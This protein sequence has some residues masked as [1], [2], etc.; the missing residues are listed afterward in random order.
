MRP[1]HLEIEGFTAFREKVAIDFDGLDLFA[2]TGPTGAGKSSLLDAAILALYGQVPRVS[3][4]YK[5]LISHGA[6]RMSVRLDFSVGERA[7]R[8]ARTIRR[9]GTAQSRLERVEGDRVVPIADRAAEVSKEVERLLGLDYDAFV[10]SVVLPQGQ[11]DEFLKGK[12][13]ERR[14]I[15]VTLLNLDVYQKMQRL[16]NEK[17]VEARREAEFLSKQLATTLAEATPEALERKRGEARTAEAAQAAAEKA[18]GALDAML[19]LARALRDAQHEAEGIGRDLAA[20]TQ[21]AQKARADLGGAEQERRALRQARDAADTRLKKAPFDHERH[22]RLTEARPRLE[23]L[24]A[25]SERM[26]QLERERAAHTRDL[27]KGKAEADRTVAGVAAA[28][29]GSVRAQKALEAAEAAREAAHARHAAHALRRQLKKGEPCPVCEH[30][31]AKL[32]RGAAPAMDAAEAALKQARKQ[33]EGAREAAESA[34]LSADRAA[35]EAR[36]VEGGARSVE[37]QLLEIGRESGALHAALGNAFAKRE[38]ASPASVLKSVESELDGLEA[39]ASERQRLEDELR[40]VESRSS[41]HEMDVARAEASVKE[42]L[43]R[44]EGLA[45]RQATNAARFEA[46]RVRLAAR[47]VEASLADV[48]SPPAGRDAMDLIEQHRVGARRDAQESAALLA[49]LRSE[50]DRLEK[51]AARAAEIREQKASLEKD[52]GLL[53]MLAQTLRADQF[54]AYVQ[55]EALQVLAEDASR[56]LLA[57]SQGRYALLFRDQDFAVEDRW[58]GDATRS[59]K[60]LSGGESFQAS[61]ALALA[62]AERVAD[63]SVEGHAGDALESLFLDEGFGSLDSEA[64]DQVVEALDHLHGGKRMVGVVTH[65]QGLAER[66]PARVEVRPGDSGSRVSVV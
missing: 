42:A 21:R 33:A 40:R 2:I 13:E 58:N 65:I 35:A 34:R 5:Q 41:Q 36:R 30:K 9:E 50:A 22:L 53:N 66:L 52:A 19:P 63:L 28:E 7:Y 60:T 18:L 43:G 37:K 51:D 17:A 47:A 12:P 55:E 62:L 56:H 23:R 25:V 31:V 3:K 10:R 59:V 8:I 54:L 32:P 64:L 4:E 6:E 45:Q 29:R 20:E 57:L 16:A 24:V 49:R 61:L 14:R 26:A 1:R 11:F 38:L 46:A 15:L 44:L 48:A 27:V 39:A